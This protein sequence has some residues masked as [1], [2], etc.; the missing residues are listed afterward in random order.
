[1]IQCEG[2]MSLMDLLA[3]V[4]VNKEPP[5]LLSEGQTVYKV[6]RGDVEIHV[7][8]GE[9]WT[10]NESNR[11]YRLKRM[12]GCWD[13]TWNTQINKIIFANLEEAK[14][15][16]EQYFE[17]NEHILAGNIKATEVVAYKIVPTYGERIAFYAVL[18]D[19]TVYFHYDCMYDHIGS[20]C[21]IESFENNR[22]TTIGKIG[23]Y[24]ILDNY[25]PEYKNMYKCNSKGWKYAEARYEFIDSRQINSNLCN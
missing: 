9:T 1:M 21:E 22:Q 15:I 19:G 2:Q 8:T 16:A 10:C 23:G 5:I 7:V 3:P 11:G 20:A 24:E 14:R 25:Q 13:C 4:V 18:E 17:K 6:V 12:G